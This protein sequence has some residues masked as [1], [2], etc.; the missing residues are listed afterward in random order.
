MKTIASKSW[1]IKI[2][3]Y[4]SFVILVLF[5]IYYP[6][7]NLL[8]SLEIPVLPTLTSMA[9][10]IAISI[11][12]SFFYFKKIIIFSIQYIPYYSLFVLISS[13]LLILECYVFKTTNYIPYDYLT[14]ANTEWF[15]FTF[16]GLFLAFNFNNTIQFLRD[17]PYS[18]YF[19]S[20]LSIITPIILALYFPLIS[21]LNRE[22]FQKL[23]FS[24]Q[25]YSD[26]LALGSFFLIAKFYNKINISFFIIIF[27]LVELFILGSRSSIIFYLL[28]I[29]LLYIRDRK[30]TILMF[31]F[32]CISIIFSIYFDDI[33]NFYQNDNRAMSL[34]SENYENDASLH[35][36][37][38][39]LQS[40]LKVIRETWFTGELYGEF[41][42][43]HK[44]GSYIHNYLSYLV[45]FGIISFIILTIIFLKIFYFFMRNR[46]TS[47][48][49]RL[50]FLISF[51]TIFSMLFS[52]SYSASWVLL[53]LPISELYINL[54]KKSKINYTKVY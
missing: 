47:F 19:L 17:K 12:I 24:F 3:T 6:L 35:E 14:A 10:F 45:N 20:S 5:L 11:V 9:P 38:I 28:S 4:F 27:V 48:E 51:F 13:I 23:H 50:I 32:L 8:Y 33:S 26:F 18:L 52:R 37:L 36:R 44:P 30:I 46:F 40:N 15:F 42:F 2:N 21:I 43:T 53:T 29:I 54:C 34:L 49:Y 31:A 22:I 7:N 41:T 1:S 16:T 39:Q 25:M